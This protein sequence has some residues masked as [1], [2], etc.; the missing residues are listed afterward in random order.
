MKIEKVQDEYAGELWQA[1][2]D[3]AIVTNRPLVE[4]PFHYRNTVHPQKYYDLYACIGW[5]T[6]VTDKDDGKPGYI[7]VVGIV[8]NNRLPQESVFQLLAEIEQRD[9]Q[10]LLS[11]FVELRAEY[12][13]G[14]HPGL[15]QT[16]FGDPDRFI[17]FLA[18]MNE[19]LTAKG[20]ERAAILVSP[21]DDFYS[22][23]VFDNYVRAL[24]SCLRAENPRLFFGKCDIL[25]N[26]VREFRRDDPVVMGI[27][28]LCHSLLSRCQ[29]MDQTRENLFVVEEERDENDVQTA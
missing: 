15:L 29:W 11:K 13:F 6:E 5:P 27:G 16:L 18:L 21:P 28:G 26:R 23:K 19:G 22:G 1:R 12:G 7:A 17:T 10:S 8:K 20:G 4:R 25:K 14:L 3:E 9:I 24:K 2:R